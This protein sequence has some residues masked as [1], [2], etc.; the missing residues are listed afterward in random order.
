MIDGD[1]C[2]EGENIMDCIQWTEIYYT[3]DISFDLIAFEDRELIEQ[4]SFLS[5]FPH[6]SVVRSGEEKCVHKTG[7]DMR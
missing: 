4:D 7:L 6:G 5:S 1:N 3:D 2:E